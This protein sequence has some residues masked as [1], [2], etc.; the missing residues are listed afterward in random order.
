MLIIMS[1][2][3]QQIKMN[4]LHE[5]FCCNLN[6]RWCKSQKGAKEQLKV[7]NVLTQQ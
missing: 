7:L 1:T 3:E 2:I 5:V 6:L 4:F